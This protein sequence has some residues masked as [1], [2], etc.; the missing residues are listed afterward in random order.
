[1]GDIISRFSWYNF[2]W[3]RIKTFCRSDLELLISGIDGHAMADSTSPWDNFGWEYLKPYAETNR[4]F[5]FLTGTSVS[6]RG[7]AESERY[8]QLMNLDIACK[9]K[10]V[11]L[12]GMPIGSITDFGRITD[13]ETAL[14]FNDVKRAEVEAAFRVTGLEYDRY[15]GRVLWNEDAGEYR[16]VFIYDPVSFPHSVGRYGWNLE[17]KYEGHT[18]S[19]Y[20]AARTDARQAPVHKTLWRFKN[21][22]DPNL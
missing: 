4:Y 22:R 5:R 10:C 8:I 2:Y 14:V 19:L 12:G 9:S 17:V 11:E 3:D 15:E 21:L 20:R 1:M 18:N 16:V 6:S 13:A 7:A